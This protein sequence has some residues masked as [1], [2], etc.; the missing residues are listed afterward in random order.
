M[1]FII[2][3]P[4]FLLP[5]FLF[6]WFLYQKVF[7]GNS[8]MLGLAALIIVLATMVF[9][10]NKFKWDEKLILRTSKYA[11]RFNNERRQ[12]NLPLLTYNFTQE[13]KSWNT[14]L[15]SVSDKTKFVLLQKVVEEDDEHRNAELEYN[16]L[17]KAISDT[18]V[19]YLRIQ[20]NFIT[21]NYY[22]ETRLGHLSHPSFTINNLRVFDDC[23][24]KPYT[25][26]QVDSMLKE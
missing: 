21:K 19:L 7:E 2:L 17:A 12:N 13:G 3:A 5:V 4:I 23:C 11:L 18:T 6:L 8:L 20:Y 22:A 14:K 24:S 1:A 16:F 15:D 9:F 25:K 10:F 26:L